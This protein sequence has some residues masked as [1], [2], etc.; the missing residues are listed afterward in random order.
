MIGKL[1]TM[2]VGADAMA[3]VPLT[4]LEITADAIVPSLIERWWVSQQGFDTSENLEVTI[5][6]IDTLGTGTTTI[7]P[8]PLSPGD[9][10]QGVSAYSHTIEPTYNATGTLLIQGFNVLSGFLWTPASDDEVMLVTAATLIGMKL[11]TEAP[12]TSMDFAYGCTI[13]EMN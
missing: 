1:Y 2:T 12:S 4:M 5:G 6:R 7:V 11:T 3:A 8:Q 13:R 9:T 10:Y